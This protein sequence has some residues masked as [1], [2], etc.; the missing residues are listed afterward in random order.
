MD[1]ENAK[2]L[3]F[4]RT[5]LNPRASLSGNL[6]EAPP[7]I[8]CMHTFWGPGGN[9]VFVVPMGKEG[10]RFD[11]EDD[12]EAE[13]IPR[14]LQ[15]MCPDSAIPISAPDGAAVGTLSI[16]GN[17]SEIMLVKNINVTAILG[18]ATLS[19]DIAKLRFGETF[20]RPRVGI[21]SLPTIGGCQPRAWEYPVVARFDGETLTVV[22]GINSAG[23]RKRESTPTID[24]LNDGEEL[25]VR[26]PEMTVKLTA[27][28]TN[29]VVSALLHGSFRLRD[30]SSERG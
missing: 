22:L 20:T 8:E 13:L 18:T 16:K 4:I 15:I 29:T 12:P 21:A 24:A 1:E 28:R 19:I 25:I 11:G 30:I 17:A 6:T 9:V 10:Y 7:Y 3:K 23:F 2:Q 27:D 14:P 5:E 26:A